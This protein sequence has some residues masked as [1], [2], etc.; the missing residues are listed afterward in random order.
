MLRTLSEY[1]LIFYLY[2]IVGY[3][4]EILSIYRSKKKFV[5]NRGYLLGPYLPV[6]GF[7]ALIIT[8]F[9]KDYQNNPI[10]LFI[11]G[12]VYCGTLEYFTSLI[13]EKIFHLRWWDYSKRKFNINGRICLE[14]STMFGIG[15]IILVNV[16]NEIVLKLLRMIPSH[17]IIPIAIVISI[18]MIGDFI[19][20][21]KEIFRL[22]ND[23]ILVGTKDATAE[24][25]KKIKESLEKNYYY[26]ERLFKA[27]PSIHDRDA[28]IEEIKKTME[29]LKIKRDQDE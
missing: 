14:T 7:G 13:L 10:T 28:R 8:I 18:I 15:A 5:W 25:K 11:L 24:I 1:F 27:F 29:K 16:S 23:I 12:M 21:T 19:I 26:Y 20:S 9:L 22:K 4:C 3:F 6:F 17:V 2:S